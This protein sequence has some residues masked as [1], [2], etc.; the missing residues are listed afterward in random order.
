MIV[1]EHLSC[2]NL[3]TLCEGVNKDRYKQFQILH[4]MVGGVGAATPSPWFLH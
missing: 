4:G 3:G 2:S 1:D